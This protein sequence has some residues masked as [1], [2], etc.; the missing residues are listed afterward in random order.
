MV[1]V[2]LDALQW[3]FRPEN[4]SGGVIS[5][6]ADPPMCKLKTNVQKWLN[7]DTIRKD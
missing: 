3:I 6:K 4:G 7:V 2:E 1:L 5:A